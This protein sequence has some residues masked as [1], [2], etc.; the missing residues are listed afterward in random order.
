MAEVNVQ[1]PGDGEWHNLP[2]PAGEQDRPQAPE[3]GQHPPRQAPREANQAPQTI[4][5]EA[6]DQ[7]GLV[8]L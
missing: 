1:Q 5:P 7:D 8:H 6:P 2:H 4:D 3:G